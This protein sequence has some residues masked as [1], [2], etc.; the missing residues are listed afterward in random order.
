MP[1]ALQQVEERRHEHQRIST[2]QQHLAGAVAFATKVVKATML[3]V[4]IVLTS[5]ATTL[6]D[7]P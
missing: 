2:L 6:K 7:S 5:A 3:V 1:S 4:R